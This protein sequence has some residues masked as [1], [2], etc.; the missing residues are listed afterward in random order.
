MP[1][2]WAI[3]ARQTSLDGQTSLGGQR[4]RCCRGNTST[5]IVPVG[6]HKR[7]LL[8][9][10]LLVVAGIVVGGASLLSLP[11]GS[12][13]ASS[14]PK[15]IP[16]GI[17]R[18]HPEVELSNRWED[19]VYK[20]ETDQHSDL[21]TEIK[22]TIKLITHW[23]Q[24]VLTLAYDAS[25]ERYHSIGSENNTNHQATLD[26]TLVLPTRR[27]I[28]L[29]LGYALLVEH[30]ERGT[31]ESSPL[32][33]SGTT[34]VGPNRWIQQ[35]LTASTEIPFNRL[36]AVLSLEH[37]TR[38]STNNDQSSQDRYWNDAGLTLNWDL[39]AKTKLL[40]E[41]GHK[42]I[43]YDT[44]PLLDSDESRLLLGLTWQATG[45]T[46]GSLKF[47]STSKQFDNDSDKNSKEITWESGIAWSP[48]KRTTVNFASSRGFQDGGE[49][50]EHYIETT[51]QVDLKHD[52]RRNWSLLS[53]LDYGT[54]DFPSVRNENTLDSTL[55]F[56]YR[57][58]RWFILNAEFAH[59]IKRS[60]VTDGGY[61]SNGLL[62][63]LEGKL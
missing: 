63:S 3:S 45:K 23:S 30:D 58:R 36:S 62:L 16:L 15:G 17:F 22:P 33:S 20:T 26:F 47:G 61:D 31:P 32:T 18:V 27:R 24:H 10:I 43:I 25:I 4:Q 29:D 6:H 38:Q 12:Q 59:K 35:T 50:A 34:F 8:H 21:I 46:T 54:S 14:G 44:S 19:N 37:A 5:L 57:M 41:L 11:N 1:N 42:Q 53:S 13:G 28:T 48:R 9:P 51:F 60:S 7:V 49:A 56:E 40:T 2:H 52:L 55:G 39:T